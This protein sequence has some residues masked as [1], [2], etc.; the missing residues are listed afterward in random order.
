LQGGLAGP[1]EIE[2]GRILFAATGAG[3]GRAGSGAKVGIDQAA[4]AGGI[5]G[6]VDPDLREGRLDRQLARD[7]RRV[8]VEDACADAMLG[9]QVRE[10]V[11]LG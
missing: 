7:A 10:E 2:G 3:D 9:E 1:A 6:P 4:R 8:G 11:R 5:V